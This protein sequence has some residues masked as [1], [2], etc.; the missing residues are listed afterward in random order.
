MAVPTERAAEHE[1][2]LVHLDTRRRPPYRCRHEHMAE[3][4]HAGLIGR[5]L[6]GLRALQHQRRHLAPKGVNNQYVTITSM[7]Q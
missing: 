1:V 7:S 3:P 4:Q 2:W 5:K 6:D